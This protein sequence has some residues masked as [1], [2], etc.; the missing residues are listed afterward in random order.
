MNKPKLTI[1]IPAYN[2][3]ST[4]QDLINKVSNLEINKQ[5]ILVDDN[6][7]DGTS[8]IIK[9]NQNKIDNIIFH[10]ENMGKGAYSKRAKIY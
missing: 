3:I 10:K 1:I 8:E 2:E 9:K 6:S 4:I 5:I 7:K